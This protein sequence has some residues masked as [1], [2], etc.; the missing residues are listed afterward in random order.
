MWRGSKKPLTKDD[1][2]NLN[3]KDSSAHVD[4]WLAQFW[5]EYDSFCKQPSKNLPRLWGSIT[6][7]A[8]K[9]LYAPSLLDLSCLTHLF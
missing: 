6:K 8:C 2:Y 1:L 3:P 4:G 5:T 7:R 9:F